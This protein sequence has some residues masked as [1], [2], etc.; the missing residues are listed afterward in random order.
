MAPKQNPAT[1]DRVSCVSFGDWT[2]ETS[3]L[4]AYRVQFLIGHTVRAEL[5]ETVAALAFGGANHG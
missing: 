5:A 1:E 3:T 4:S 2:Q